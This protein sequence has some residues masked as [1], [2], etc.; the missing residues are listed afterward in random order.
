MAALE[1]HYCTGVYNPPLHA[2][3]TVNDLFEIRPMVLIESHGNNKWMT[4]IGVLIQIV[5]SIVTLVVS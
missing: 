1:G 2:Q 5:I 4:V 3:K